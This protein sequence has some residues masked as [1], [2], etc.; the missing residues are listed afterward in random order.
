MKIGVISDTHLAEAWGKAKLASKLI[1]KVKEDTQAL[2]EILSPHFS[3]VDMIIHAGDLVD[4][5]VVAMLE[6]FAPVNAVAGNMDPGSV[7]IHLEDKLIVEAG[8][9]KIGV[10]HG[11]GS[12]SN[13]EKRVRTIFENDTVDCIV[14]GHSHSP[15]NQRM[16]GVLMFNPG[17]PT[18]RRF[19]PSRAIGILELNDEIRGTIIEL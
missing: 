16:D 8:D 9:F 3:G 7:K 13:I 10:T 2:K 6:Q 15:F 19:A 4:M 12:P 14:F 5:Q 17:S 1:T 11:Y 18:D